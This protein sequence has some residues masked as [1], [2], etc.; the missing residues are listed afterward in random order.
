MKL[1]PRKQLSGQLAVPAVV[2]P[3]TIRSRAHLR[4][5]TGGDWHGHLRISRIICDARVSDGCRTAMGGWSTSTS[6]RMKAD[7]VDDVS[8]IEHNVWWGRE[9]LVLSLAVTLLDQAVT[10]T[11]WQVRAKRRRSEKR[12]LRLR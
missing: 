5:H 8:D 9:A 3:A 12:P 6:R 7:G 11:A 2:M 4:P 1:K 10:E